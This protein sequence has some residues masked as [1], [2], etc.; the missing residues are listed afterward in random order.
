M[1][2]NLEGTCFVCG[3]T[4]SGS[5]MTRH[6]KSCLSKA[7]RHDDD[8]GLLIRASGE[9]APHWLYLLAP[10]EGT[11]ADLDAFLRRI[12]LECCNHL[13]QFAI[14]DTRYDSGGGSPSFGPF[15]SSSESMAIQLGNVVSDG[16]EFD[17]TYDF[18]SSTPLSL[19]CYG[20]LPWPAA[21]AMAREP[22][23]P[24]PQSVWGLARNE[25][26][27]LECDV[28]GEPADQICSNCGGLVCDGHRDEHDCEYSMFLPTVNSPRMGVCGYTG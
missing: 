13:S 28:C 27:A 14:D 26:P 9:W 11:L 8:S 23:R 24:G 18:G 1:A 5:G 22:E 4:Y 12:W 19:K 16:T 3:N 15:G 2:K 21:D 25:P 20:D 6:L 10:T 17:Y 7:E